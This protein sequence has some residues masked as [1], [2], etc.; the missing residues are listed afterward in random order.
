MRI[1]KA[2][3]IL[4]RPVNKLFRIEHTYHDTNLTDKARE[5]NLRWEAA[6]IG[7]L[8]KN[9]NVNRVNMEK[10]EESLNITNIN[11]LVTFNKTWKVFPSVTQ[12]LSIFLTTAAPSASVERVHSKEGLP[13]VPCSIPTTSHAQRWALCSNNPANA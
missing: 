10:D 2:S 3:A 12:V 4:K 13:K 9:M 7:E 6:V 5:Q 8:K 11:F 1:K